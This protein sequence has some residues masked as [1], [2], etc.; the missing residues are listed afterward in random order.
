MKLLNYIKSLLF[1]EVKRT[2]LFEILEQEG[3]E[4]KDKRPSKSVEEITAFLFP[5]LKIKPTAD[6]NHKFIV[7]GKIPEFTEEDAKN[8]DKGKRIDD[9][10]SAL[11]NYDKANVTEINTPEDAAQYINRK[12]EI[13]GITPVKL[14]S[15]Q[16]EWK[17]L[18][19]TYLNN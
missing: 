8:L 13:E 1:K 12:K 3:C 19:Y 11:G 2:H 14:W 6:Y 7:V 10:I 15:K 17:E 16:R 5:D 18:N 4:I 9:C